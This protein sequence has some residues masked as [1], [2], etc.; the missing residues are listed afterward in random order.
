MRNIWTYV[1]RLNV[2]LL[3]HVSLWKLLLWEHRLEVMLLGLIFWRCDL[4]CCVRN[5][6][7]TSIASILVFLVA[8]VHLNWKI[9]VI[10]DLQL[11]SLFTVS[12]KVLRKTPRVLGGETVNHALNLVLSFILCSLDHVLVNLYVVNNSL[13]LVNGRGLIW[14]KSHLPINDK[15][16]KIL[17]FFHI[18]IWLRLTQNYHRN[19]E[20]WCNSDLILV[21]LNDVLPGC[22]WAYDVNLLASIVPSN[23]Y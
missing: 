3:E 14:G 12:F 5:A 2:Q 19:F 8:F 11:A 20:Y 17:T 7:L 15:V 6:A 1:H 9:D 16:V 22:K 13:I 23:T 21:H 4:A 10:I 18:L